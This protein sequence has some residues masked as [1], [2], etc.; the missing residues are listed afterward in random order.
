MTLALAAI[1][2]GVMAIL[3]GMRGVRA[4]AC[5]GLLMVLIGCAASHW[6]SSA[7]LVAVGIAWVPTVLILAAAI[8]ALRARHAASNANRQQDRNSGLRSRSSPL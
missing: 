6:K 7:W 3:A 4:Y 1:W 8:R 5:Q 2:F